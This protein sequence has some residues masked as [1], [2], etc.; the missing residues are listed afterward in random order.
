MLGPLEVRADSGS[1]VQ[2]R[3][4]RLRALLIVLALETS[5][6]VT[7]RRLVDA[8]W[9]DQTPAGVGNALQAL[10]SRLRRTV[11]DAKII[12]HPA[13]YQ[14]M[15]SP[16]QVDVFRFE[17]LAAAGHDALRADPARAAS[18]LREAL[19]LWRGPALADVADTDFAQVIGARLDE[20]RLTAIQD[21]VDA[22]LRLGV[23]GPLVPELEGLVAAYP[24]REP[25]IGQLM[26]A[27]SGSGQPAAALALYEQARSRLVEQLG[28]EPSA[29]LAAVH[30]EIL[31][32]G[33]APAAGDRLAGAHGRRAGEPA[34]RTAPART[35]GPRPP[36]GATSGPGSPA[37]G[38]AGNEPPASGPAGSRSAAAD[39]AGGNRSPGRPSTNL[40]A[41]LTSFVGRDAELAEVSEL[42]GA[43]RLTTLTGPGGAG[44]TRLA[45]EAARAELGAMAG[46]VWLIELAPVTDPA[47]VAPTA[48]ATMGLR[49]HALI[50]TP[51]A[52]RVPDLPSDPLGRLVAALSGQQALL[53]LDNCE[54]LVAAAAALAYRVLGACPQV[55]IIATSREPLNI[56]GEVLWP[57]RPLALPPPGAAPD[58]AAITGYASV[59]L[60]VQ[61]A[62]AVH[63]GFEVTTASAAAVAYICQ[64][65]DGMPL[66]IELAAARLRAMTPEQVAER[67][68]DRFRLLT[69]GSRAALPR[70]QTLRAVVSWSWDLLD[71]AER[72][73]WRRF[74]VFAGGATLAAAERVCSG[75]AVD[76]GQVLDLLTALMDKSL[77]T[78]RPGPDGPRYRMLEIIRAYGQERLAEAGEQDALRTVHTAYFAGLADLA[79]EHLLGPDQLPWLHQL[80]DDQD[81][82]H[83]ALRGC[84]QAGDAPTALRLAGSLGW[85]W[86]LR[87]LKAEGV[88][89]TGEALAVPGEAPAE[90]R[91]VAYTMGALLSV[92]G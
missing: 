65:L 38:P 40:R 35:P 54:H 80:T 83:A 10:V 67:L 33:H 48:L 58:P 45:V 63:P 59:Q 46:G 18:L 47:E 42:I 39:E 43:H 50:R 73:L 78:V 52:A 22:E 89:L 7:T 49:E 25:L 41:E 60:L 56:T 28:T 21:R 3:G 29:G 61:R 70:H 30:L 24:L 64:A 55:R 81:N 11:P 75:G 92:D 85:Y 5:R 32:A 20:L 68:D 17:Q 9:G 86:W 44:K 6:V 36:A 1:V 77:L 51:R 84:V 8:L 14:L 12:A 26:R 90:L 88:E 27:L 71:E 31:R 62:R 4:A 72:A 76:S 37:R 53:V 74:S 87:G 2:L 23:T 19:A 66:A 91:A 34:G 69:G 79:Q 15:L 82:L 16:Q 57:V 13:G